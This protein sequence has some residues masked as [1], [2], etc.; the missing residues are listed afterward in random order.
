MRFLLACFLCLFS[1]PAIAQPPTPQQVASA[2]RSAAGIY[3]GNALRSQ[4]TNP[5]YA[6]YVAGARGDAIRTNPTSNLIP[7]GDSVEAQAQT[8]E[9]L[10]DAAVAAAA[11]KEA[12]GDAAYTAGNYLPA[13]KLY[14]ESKNLWFDAEKAWRKVIA[15]HQGAAGLYQKAGY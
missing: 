10:A 4:Q 5:L 2:I 12:Q 15:G 11:A 8:D 14:A 7:R 3:K 13:A 1:A 6:P 9:P